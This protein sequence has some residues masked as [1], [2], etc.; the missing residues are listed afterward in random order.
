MLHTLMTSPFQCDL[1][2]MLRL[3]A[4]GDD[5]LLLQ[6]GVLAAL[7]G[8][9]ALESLRLA[10]I[11]LYVLQDDVVARGLSA[12]ISSDAAAVSYTDFVALTVKHPQQ[13]T[14]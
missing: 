11:S 14:W 5:V 2:A 13:M 12:Q 9:K 3:L 10:P 4:E 6:D 1:N 7:K 8:C